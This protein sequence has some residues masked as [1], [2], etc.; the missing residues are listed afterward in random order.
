MSTAARYRAGA[1]AK[2]LD[3][4][5]YEAT[6]ALVCPSCQWSGPTREA[7]HEEY[8]ELFRRVMPQVPSDAAYRELPGSTRASR[9]SVIMRYLEI[10]MPE[11]FMLEF[12]LEDGT[13][14]D[15]A[16]CCRA[17]YERNPDGSYYVPGHSGSLWI[18]AVS[19]DA[20]GVIEH[21]DQDGHGE[22]HRYRLVPFP[23][24]SY[25]PR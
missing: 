11:R 12:Q 5:E 22:R 21:V 14:M 15:E 7:D 10:P 16:L 2:Q 20:D 8:S 3:A 13:W 23:S 24:E 6:A 9:S 25:S 17:D 1:R 4:D 19:I 18:R